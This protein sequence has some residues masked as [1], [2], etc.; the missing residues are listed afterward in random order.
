MRARTL[1]A[2]NR[3]GRLDE[4]ECSLLANGAAGV[5]GWYFHAILISMG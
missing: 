3:P 1:W 5:P 4:L 2:P